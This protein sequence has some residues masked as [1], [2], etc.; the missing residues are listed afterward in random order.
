MLTFMNK[1]KIYYKNLS[2][3]HISLGWLKWINGK[4]AIEGLS[5][6]K[7]KTN[8]ADLIKYLKVSK[9]KKNK[10]YAVYDN[11]NNV[12]IGN[13]S[14]TEIDHINKHCKYGRFLGNSDYSKQGY[15]QMMLLHL[16][17]IAFF[18]LKLNKCYTHVFTNNIPSIKSN[19]KFGMKE[20]GVLRQNVL[21]DKKYRNVIVFS[22]L[23]S[24]FIK[25]YGK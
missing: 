12:Y 17:R 8:K 1:N 21:K 5:T 16:F 11:L 7:K 22:M 25:R 23:K 4:E 2:I 3:N 10:L 18:K 19:K 20:E 6:I 14:L 13:M 15:G 9:Q 24:E